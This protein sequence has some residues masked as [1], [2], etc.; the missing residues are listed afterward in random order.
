MEYLQ[1]IILSG[2]FIGLLRMIRSFLS[3]LPERLHDIKMEGI[4]NENAKQLQIDSFYRQT[5]NEKLMETL[6]SWI[7]V[8]YDI[9]EFSKKEPEYF[10]KMLSDVV[11]HGSEKSLSKMAD[12]QQYT[13][14]LGEGEFN[15][16]TEEEQGL[17]GMYLAS[18]VVTQLKE[19]FTGYK[20]DSEQLLRSKISDY[21]SKKDSLEK[22]KLEAI[23][24]S[25]L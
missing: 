2:F 13:Y 18:F 21:Y 3:E 23:K 10:I 6:S 1:A 20:I 12:F 19:D 24:Q 4:K 9:D 8:I 7:Q 22:C 14:K 15:D 17:I 11:L 25:T 5:S 16:F